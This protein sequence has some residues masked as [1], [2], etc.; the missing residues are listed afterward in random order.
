[1]ANN[2]AEVLSLSYLLRYPKDWANKT[3]LVSK[4]KLLTSVVV[5]TLVTG[6][7]ITGVMFSFGNVFVVDW[8]KTGVCIGVIF[9]VV[10]SFL[11][12]G[13]DN[14]G[15]IR[16]GLLFVIAS[17]FMSMGMAMLTGLMPVTLDDISERIW[18]I[19][20]F[21]FGAWMIEYLFVLRVQKST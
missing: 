6:F 7:F 11:G 4:I 14:R 16:E 1:M 12:H 21:V 19:E 2:K 20:Q 9:T 18:I 13:F 10:H 15:T 3:G 5:M 8:E 17:S